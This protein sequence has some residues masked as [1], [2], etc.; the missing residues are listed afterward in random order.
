[1][2]VEINIMVGGEAGQGVQSAGFI[3]G[4]SLARGGYHVFADQDYESRIRGGHNFFRVRARD[5]EVEAPVE[6]VDILIALNRETIELHRGELKPDSVVIFDSEKIK[7]AVAP[8]RGSLFGIPLDKTAELETGNRIMANTVA[9]GAALGLT[10]YDSGI[11]E[12]VLKQYFPGQK[13]AEANVKAGRAGYKYARDNFK[14]SFSIRLSPIENK[15]MMFLSGN[16][17]ISVGAIAAGCRFFAGYPMTPST[18]ILE[19][20]AARAK[21]V[22]LAV[23]QSE[24]EIAALN[25]A[26]GAAYAGVRAMTATS[27]SG[28]ALM[29]EALGLAGMTETPVVIVDGQRGG[30][31]VGLPTRTEQG[32]LLFVIHAAPGEF[33]RAVFAPS[34]PSDAFWLTIKAFNMAEKYQT[35]VIILNDHHL[36]TLYQTV[37]SFDLSKVEIDRGELFLPD[38]AGKAEDY[39]RHLVTESGISPRAFPGQANALVVTDADEHDEYGH[40][41]ETIEDRNAQVEKRL[42]KMSG[43]RREISSPRRY[44][45]ES[46]EG[47]L[48]GWGSSYGAIREAVDIL[49][50]DGAKVN[51]LHFTE[52]WPFPAEAVESALRESRY[53]IVVEC[54]ATHQLAQLMR[55]ETGIQADGYISRYDGRPLTPAFVVDAFKKEVH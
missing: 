46:A 23:V 38:E 11:F 12:D 31:A 2:P 24:D 42:R 15:E 29:V 37:P 52:L 45:P 4:K 30:P 8:G 7:D 54:N 47:T 22:G 21:D 51:L 36:A 20:L 53:T 55:A 13:V 43:L 26:V 6:P 3:L 19:Y 10:G 49:N 32:D 1:M 25:M 16:D 28:F 27:G 14:G 17:A 5:I 50:R 41:T 34:N 9:I 33:P 39:K 40:L 18:P 48:V 44:G 35:P